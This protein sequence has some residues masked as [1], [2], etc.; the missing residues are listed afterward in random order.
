MI[1]L[2][3]SSTALTSIVTVMHHMMMLN[4]KY[5]IVIQHLDGDG[6]VM[7]TD[8]FFGRLRTPR[9]HID[10]RKSSI[11]VPESNRRFSVSFLDS[12]CGSMVEK[13]LYNVDCSYIYYLGV[14]FETDAYVPRLAN[15]TS[16]S[17]WRSYDE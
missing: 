16:T 10:G 9:S 11:C 4:H 7:L 17:A 2:G 14:A 13:T 1:S 12:T 8:I 15:N 6:M 3:N 5:F